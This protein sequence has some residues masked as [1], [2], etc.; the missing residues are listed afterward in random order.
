MSQSQIS[1]YDIGQTRAGSGSIQRGRADRRNTTIL[2]AALAAHIRSKASPGMK[3]QILSRVSTMR[4]ALPN[5]GDT[6]RG[7]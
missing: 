1:N 3:P 2:S 7:A 6:C 4:L 5:S